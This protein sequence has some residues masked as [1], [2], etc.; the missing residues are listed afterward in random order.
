MKVLV[1]WADSK[2]AN[3][4]VRVLAQ[5][6]KALAVAA[7]GEET[8][9]DFQDY[10]PGDSK[11]GFGGRTILKDLGRPEG[12]I[13]TKLSQYDLVLDSGAGD[14]FAD[15]Y[16][17][18]RLITMNYAHRVAHEIGVALVMGP[19]TIGPFGT[20]WSRLIARS[21]LRSAT[22][23]FARDPISLG[24]SSALGRKAVLSTDVV[25]ALPQPIPSQ[26]TPRDIVMNVSGLLWNSDKHVNAV[27]YRTAVLATIAQIRS[28]GRSVSLLA[29]VIDNPTTDNDVVAIRQAARLAG[30][31]IE[32]IIPRD[33]TDVRS[34]VAGASVV[35]GARMH[36]CL[37]ALSTGTPSIPWAYSRK[38]APLL[39]D[40]GWNL[41]LDVR[42]TK[43]LPA[44]TMRYLETG[45][46]HESIER[47]NDMAATR[48]EEVIAALR[49]TRRAAA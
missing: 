13:K 31:D 38:F 22:T 25:F 20:V 41:S 49:L 47:I 43:A 24:F 42:D 40:L 48:L 16:G 39:S 44:A 46:E 9:V 19:Q 1:L 34:I 32:T 23:V 17:A 6:M 3:L 27:E 15:I 12:P 33:L 8:Q 37:N 30:G 2:S 14:S 45:F 28:S 21:S 4:G 10:G 11:I 26:V 18:K 5:G 7:F 35:I 36:S 29:H